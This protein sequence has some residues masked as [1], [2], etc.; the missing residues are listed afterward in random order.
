MDSEVE[1]DAATGSPL[2]HIEWIY[3]IGRP[4]SERSRWQNLA[5]DP[6]RRPEAPAAAR[7][8]PSEFIREQAPSHPLTLSPRLSTLVC[9]HFGPPVLP[10]ATESQGPP[11]QDSVHCHVSPI[12]GAP[13]PWPSRQ[14]P[15]ANLSQRTWPLR[16]AIQVRYHRP[17]A[18]AASPATSF[19]PPPTVESGFAFGCAVFPA[20][21]P[22]RLPFYRPFRDSFSETIPG[23]ESIRDW[24]VVVYAS[25]KRSVWRLFYA[26]APQLSDITGY[27]MRRR[28]ILDMEPFL[29]IIHLSDWW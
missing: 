27:L 6:A 5:A 7:R 15:R 17:S 19:I 3:T 18:P 2:L 14:E 10:P 1:I 12:T 9:V 8:P 13:T 4:E 28:I 21:P 22:H 23:T 26:E 20:K 16:H 25:P 29:M 24:S 11:R